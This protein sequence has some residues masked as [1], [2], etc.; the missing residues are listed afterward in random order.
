MDSGEG[1][2]A[3]DQFPWMS[4][5]EV[6]FPFLNARRKKNPLEAKLERREP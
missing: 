2:R 5:G 6:E 1:S 4:G 3:R